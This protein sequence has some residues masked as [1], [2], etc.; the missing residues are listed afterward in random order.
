MYPFDQC[1][2]HIIIVF[3]TIKDTYQENLLPRRPIQEVYNNTILPVL[4]AY[5]VNEIV[6]QCGL[7]EEKQDKNK[8]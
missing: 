1:L 7:W 2:L 6:F 5:K 3:A 8:I 4:E